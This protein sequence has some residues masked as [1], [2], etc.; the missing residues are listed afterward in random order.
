MVER[1]KD[2][3]LNSYAGA[4]YR[5]KQGFIN[6]VFDENA[7]PLDKLSPEEIDAHILGVILAN[8]YNLKKGKELFGD[9]C[10]KAVM[11]ELSEIDGLETYEPQRIEDLS[12]EDKN[13]LSSHSFSFQKGEPVRPVIL[14]SRAG[15]WQ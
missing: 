1:E 7:P 8:Q 6:H 10:D 4:G 3:I 12:Y 5:T 14:R 13:K 9:R 2:D 11:D 15:T